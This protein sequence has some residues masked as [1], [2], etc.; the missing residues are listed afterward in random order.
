MNSRVDLVK[1]ACGE[2]EGSFFSIRR[3]ATAATQPL[4][5][6]LGTLKCVFRKKSMGELQHGKPVFGWLKVEQMDTHFDKENPDSSAPHHA[7]K[8]P[9]NA[10]L[11]ATISILLCNILFTSLGAHRLCAAFHFS[12]CGHFRAGDQRYPTH[13]FPG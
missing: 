12:C 8:K 4:P 11:K 7:G 5:W 10:F 2:G 9:P 3:L 1:L 13:L 6:F